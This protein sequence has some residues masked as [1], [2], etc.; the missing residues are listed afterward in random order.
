[1]ATLVGFTQFL[2]AELLDHI[3]SD[4]AYA[5]PATLYAAVSTTTP[6]EESAGSWNFTEPGGGG[7]DRVATTAATWNAATDADPS[8]K[9]NVAEIDF[10]QAS[11]AAWGTLTYFGLFDAIT[12][13]NLLLGGAIATPKT[14]DD[15]DFAKFPVGDWDETLD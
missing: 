14:I 11:G 4:A 1:V 7:Y 9:D 12:G 15:G 13:G 8:L 5:P 2:A 6:T 10:G 3:H